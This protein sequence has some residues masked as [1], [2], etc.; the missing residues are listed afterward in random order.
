MRPRRGALQAE[1]LRINPGGYFS[2]RLPVA[3]ARALSPGKGK[4]RKASLLTGKD[5]AKL[6]D[7]EKVQ[8]AL[9]RGARQERL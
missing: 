8:A 2:E 5:R 4:L 3:E 7:P 1:R 6:R 9:K